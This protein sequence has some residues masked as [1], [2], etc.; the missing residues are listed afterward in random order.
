VTSTRDQARIFDA[1]EE[2]L[3][4]HAPPLAVRRDTPADKRNV[5]LWSEKELEIA[6]RKRTEVYFAGAIVQKGYVGFY[7]MPVY[8]DAERRGL[9]APEL[10]PLLEGKSCF[11]VKELDDKRLGQIEDALERGLDLYRQRGW[12]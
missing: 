4:R 6:G 8:T 12:I 9:F 1:I 11:H 10:L 2:V 7:Y 3:L 5:H